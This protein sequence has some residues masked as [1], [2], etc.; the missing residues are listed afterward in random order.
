M[1]A[2]I[3]K[4]RTSLAIFMLVKDLQYA[5]IQI[6]SMPSFSRLSFSFQF[7]YTYAS[8]CVYNCVMR[9]KFVLTRHLPF[10]STM[11]CRCVNSL[12]YP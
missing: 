8:F 3:I 2:I 10:V 7:M 6:S 9:L 4:V 1:M 11:I 12:R 5:L